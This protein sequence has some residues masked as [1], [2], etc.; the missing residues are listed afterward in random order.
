MSQAKKKGLGKSWDTLIL[1]GR[2]SHS[3]SQQIVWST[4]SGTWY[5]VSSL[6]SLG[7]F[8]TSL[9]LYSEFSVS[10]FH[11]Y[12]RL[13]SLWDTRG[14]CFWAVCPTYWG[15]HPGFSFSQHWQYILDQFPL[16]KVTNNSR[17]VLSLRMTEFMTDVCNVHCSH[18]WAFADTTSVCETC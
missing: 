7:L 1:A 11:E 18:H 4:W 12:P 15:F 8:C 17:G 5:P 2:T 13:N 10:S 16:D 3:V 9:W 14:S 6:N